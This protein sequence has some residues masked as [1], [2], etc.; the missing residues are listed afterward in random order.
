L[1]ALTGSSD[2]LF[3]V[4]SLNGMILIQGI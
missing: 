3:N 2:P 1:M 4:Y